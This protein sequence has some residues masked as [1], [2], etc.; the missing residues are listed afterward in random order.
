ML[1]GYVAGDDPA[2]VEEPTETETDPESDKGAW[3]PART[4]GKDANKTMKGDMVKAGDETLPMDVDEEREAAC[5]EKSQKSGIENDGQGL[6]LHVCT[7]HAIPSV[8]IK[9]CS[10]H[11]V[12]G[13]STP[14]NRCL[15]TLEEEQHGRWAME[16]GVQ[17]SLTSPD[18]VSVES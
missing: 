3:A 6:Y 1:E 10:S 11:A 14:R 17:G 12:S 7:V 15:T 16:D 5:V 4:S 2:F 9:P 13:G 8:D 18:V